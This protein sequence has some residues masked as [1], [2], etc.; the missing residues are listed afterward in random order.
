M[1]ARPQFPRGLL[2][3][4]VLMPRKRLL[5]SHLL[6]TVQ[7]EL[8]RTISGAQLAKRCNR[9]KANVATVFVLTFS[10]AISK[11]LHESPSCKQEESISKGHQ[12]GPLLPCPSF[13]D[14]VSMWYRVSSKL[15]HSQ[16]WPWPPASPAS[17]CKSWCYRLAPPCLVYDVLETPGEIDKCCSNKDLSLAG[18]LSVNTWIISLGT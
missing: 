1:L 13:W 14:R 17:T 11:P 15:L 3:L 8:L 12:V 16:R 4:S 10:N 7:L 2:E 9:P 18:L 5:C 6:C